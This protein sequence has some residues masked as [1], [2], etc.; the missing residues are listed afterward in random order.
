MLNMFAPVAL[1]L[2]AAS[3]PAPAPASHPLL[4]IDEKAVQRDEPTPHGKIGMSTAFRISDGVPDRTMEFRKR[5]LHVGSAIGAHPID[6]DEVY[7]VVSGTGEV[8]SG[9]ETKTVTAG[10]AAY[11][12]RG[13]TVGIKQ[14]GKA[15]LSLIIAYPVVAK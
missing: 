10:M 7:Y 2:L 3:P 8:M 13:E 12:Y 9:G 14:V 11:L 4:V 15:P 1:A 5:I 6:H